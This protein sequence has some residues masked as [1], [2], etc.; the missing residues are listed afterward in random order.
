MMASKAWVAA[1]VFDVALSAGTAPVFAQAPSTE[2]AARRPSETQADPFLA[3]DINKNGKIDAAEA[4]SAA[5]ARFDDVNP[6]LDDALTP[7][8]AAP[9]LDAAAFRE[10]DAD[11]DGT[12][13]K[14]EYLAYVERM[15]NKA[16]PAPDGLDRAQLDTDAGRALLRLMR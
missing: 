14:A 10:V 12:I 2:R 11:G 4:K 15:F 16:N 1:A 9:L 13:N 5:A 8:E 6:A 7:Q 3:L